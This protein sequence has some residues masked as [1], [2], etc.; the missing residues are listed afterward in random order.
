[1]GG[2]PATARK[3][4]SPAPGQPCGNVEKSRCTRGPV[5]RLPAFGTPSKPQEADCA[6]PSFE[7]LLEVDDSAFQSDGNGV[8]P[9]ICAQFGENVL[10]VALHGFFR[11]GE[12]G[13]DLF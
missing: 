12:L 8:S 10:D 2:I 3:N 5:I 4:T 9:V 11:D 6:N 7:G 1:M 13:G